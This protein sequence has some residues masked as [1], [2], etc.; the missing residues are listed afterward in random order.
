MQLFR[1]ELAG[2][3]ADCEGAPVMSSPGLL[4]FVLAENHSERAA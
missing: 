3:R 2:L 4:R 1:V